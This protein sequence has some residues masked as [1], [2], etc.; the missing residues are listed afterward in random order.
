LETGRE[1]FLFQA[2]WAKPV[3]YGLT[4]LS[5]ALCGWQVLQMLRLW[6]KGRP[7]A[8]TGAGW[9]GIVQF[10]FGQ[11]KVKQARAKDGAPM[12]LA[13]FYGFLG[14]FIA[15]SLL[16]LATYSPLIGLANWHKGTYYLVYEFL[17]DTA[18]LVF[19]VG[20]SWAFIRRL[21]YVVQMGPAKPNAEGKLSHTKNPLTTE[22]KDW[23]V[24]ALLAALAKTG[25][26]V[27]GLRMVVDPSSAVSASYVGHLYAQ[28][29]TGASKEVYVAAW[30]VHAAL[31][32]AFFATL[33]LMRIK[34]IVVAFF[35]F[36]GKPDWPMGRLQ[37]IDM[38]EV[39]KTGLVGAKV[40]TDFSQWHLTTLDACMS[41]GRCTEVC[42]AYGVG[43]V[44][45]PKQI[46]QDIHRGLRV[47]DDLVP[48]VTE[49]AIWA[50][51]TCNACVEACP[52]AIRHVDM[53]VDMRRDQVAEGMLSGTATTVL[54]QIGST[55]H[56]WGQPASSR[57]D[58]MK[59][60]DIPLARDG[61]PFEFLF[62][63]GCAGATD[64]A[65]VRTTK[66]V[67]R[68]LKKA[69]VSFACLGREEAC[70]GD[71]ARRIGDEFTFIEQAGKNAGVFEK[72]GVKK[73]VTACPHCLN[74]LLNEYGDFGAKME[75]LHHTQLLAELVGQKRLNAAQPRG[76]V[77]LH[78]PCY[79]ARVNGI[80][81][82][83]RR[84]L[85]EDSDLDDKSEL[86]KELTGGMI[87]L[88]VLTEAEHNGKK[89]LCCGAGGGRMWMDDH[90]TQR[91]ADRR[92]KE[93][94]ET[95]ADE[96]AVAC[97]FCRIMLEPALKQEN[98]GIRLVDLAELM[99]EANG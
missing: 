37:P 96:V 39:E 81:D 12:H 51:T 7:S 8:W 61:K 3:F 93:L 9:S 91:P 95:G 52:V 83:P 60:L 49:E 16:G 86:Q 45:N 1:E 34:H 92:V 55:G 94:L 38:D 4:F 87:P 14:L 97:P 42:P 46:V 10:V 25:F 89:T 62:W 20:V 75:V 68:L 41:C 29:L 82:A 54:R 70:T 28:I 40:A 56:A 67:A 30:W 23:A 64:P 48:R 27:E 74:T 5:L 6:Q 99:Q 78:D 47:G 73:V 21:A 35:G 80:V 84:L 22:W 24:L 57:E 50:C 59:G 33:P 44:L 32:W 17:A 76:S 63:V 19:L 53:I 18:G 85:G 72:Y 71:P 36:A 88:R 90:P 2:A 65:A 69:G 66:A 79:L 98:E 43:K 13:I 15:T 11:R 58:W 31:V 26:L 77:T